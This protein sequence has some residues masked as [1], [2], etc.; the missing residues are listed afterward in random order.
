MELFEILEIA[1]LFSN[2]SRSP[3]KNIK[4]WIVSYGADFVLKLPLSLG[5]TSV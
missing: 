3:W 1:E 5:D 2:F 4:A